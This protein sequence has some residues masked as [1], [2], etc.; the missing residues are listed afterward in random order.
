M[1]LLFK[2]IN[3]ICLEVKKSGL[4]ENQP[5]SLNSNK[6]DLSPKDVNIIPVTVFDNADKVFPLFTILQMH[7]SLLIYRT[8]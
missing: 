2:M 4:I 8:S 1:P 5:A 7:L 3:N 6:R